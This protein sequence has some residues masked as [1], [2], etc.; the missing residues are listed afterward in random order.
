MSA[1]DVAY[2]V[3]WEK[4]TGIT[5]NLAFNGVG[6]C[7]ADKA[8]DESSAKCSGSI[9]DNGATF[10]D[11]GQSVNSSSPNDAGLVN[12]LL[13]NQSSFNWIN[14]TWS[15]LFL[16]CTTS[17]PQAL[18]TVTANSTGG[19]FSAGTYSYEVTAATAYGESEPSLPQTAVVGANGSVALTWP[20][21]TNGT[22][23]D[24]TPGP[25]LAQEEA[26]HTGGTGFWGYYVYRANPGSTTFGLVGQV[27][28][29]PA[30]TAATTYSFTD[31]GAAAGRAPNS[32]PGSP[33]ATNPGI[34]CASNPS[35]WL[36]ATSTSA[37][38]S[39]E[40]EIGLN[41]A[42]A[43]ANGLTNYTPAAV[44]TGEHSGIDNPN[45]PAALAGVGVTTF[46]EDASRQ[47]QQY[48]L[49]SALGAPRYPSNIYYN[50]SNWQDELNEYNTLYVA[51]GASLG[52][53]NPAGETGHCANTTA[54][55][56]VAAPLTE[57]GLL[58]SESHIMLSHVLANDPRVGYAHQSNL[59]G[60]ATLNGQGYGY[61]L[62]GL[63]NNMLTQYN[64]WYTAPLSQMTDVSEA[65]VL[66][67][68]DAW[69]QT[70]SAGAV[71]ASETNGVVTI[72]NA[73]AA[74]NVPVTMPTGT[75]VNGAAFGQSYG[76][77]LSDW[78]NLAT[79]ATETLDLNVPPAL[80]SSASATSI[81][82]APF[83]F[84]VTTTGEPNPAVT[85]VG[86]LPGGLTFIDN[87]DG[88]A[89]IAGT[90]AAASG[91]SYPVTLTAT[92]RVRNDLAGLHADQRRS[93]DDHQPAHSRLRHGDGRH[94]QRHHHGLPGGHHHRERCAAG[95]ALLHDQG[96]R[97]RHHR[98]HG[99]HGGHLPGQPV[100]HQRVGQ[101][102]DAG[103]HS[104]RRRG[105]G[106]D[107]HQPGHRQLH[108]RAGR[109]VCRDHH[110]RAGA[111]PD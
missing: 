104:H 49:G 78:V 95:R 85:E 7:T 47:P 50:A 41:Q 105:R 14:H 107:H 24:G 58:A 90:P 66:A 99:H 12:A 92:N 15:H 57:A 77:Q 43:A 3:A 17:S 102:L 42:F 34:D 87:G 31:T 80:T 100:G 52:A 86:A 83:T 108:R 82:G 18:S 72:T 54:T 23:A 88:T 37:D 29:N 69:A 101:H 53:A 103:A 35:G 8:A 63:I 60:P 61:T 11:P 2:V 13:A 40:Q 84:R 39:I 62:L 93:P 73:G 19:S 76:G 30:A 20:E 79:G 28:E 45:M 91:G 106:P 25:S 4:Q 46:A 36:P 59:I 6:A 67:N 111:R 98:R 32:D 97:H 70:D 51:Q 44:V 71:S 110:R 68:Q 21:A 27:A 56:C 48:S 89:T 64:A 33:T 65:Q 10:T 96:Q 94:V 55:T 9:T 109:L 75:T 22:G 38:S 26:S 5:L 1:T 81:V 74:V 16:G